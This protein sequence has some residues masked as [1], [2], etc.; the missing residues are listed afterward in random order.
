MRVHERGLDGRVDRVSLNR[1]RILDEDT[2]QL[3][4]ECQLLHA[5][6]P[7]QC[8]KKFT[9]QRTGIIGMGRIIY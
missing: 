1:K 2:C 4:L 6:E 8:Y 3:I 7:T 5:D 9:C